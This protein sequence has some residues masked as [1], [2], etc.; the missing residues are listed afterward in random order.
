MLGFFILKKKKISKIL[1]I[2]VLGKLQIYPQLLGRF[3]FG[4]SLPRLTN[5]AL[6]QSKLSKSL[7][8]SF[9]CLYFP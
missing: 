8:P 4:P 9:G 5:D 6:N 1:G 7:S 3:Q 2:F